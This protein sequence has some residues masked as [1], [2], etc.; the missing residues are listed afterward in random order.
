MSSY[1]RELERQRA[2]ADAEAAEAA[3]RLAKKA[4]LERFVPLDTRLQ[5]LLASIPDAVQRKGISLEFLR[6]SLR[7]RSRG[8]CQS[9]ELGTALRKLKYHR[10]R[11]WRGNNG[12]SA[13][14]FPPDYQ[15]EFER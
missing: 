7:G 5:R 3:E 2:L 6:N 10:T 11:A 8:K 15:R 12:F 14:W 13:L 9:G 4:D 1:I